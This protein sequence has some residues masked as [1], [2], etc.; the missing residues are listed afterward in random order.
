MHSK[1][2]PESATRKAIMEEVP[3]MERAEQT[4]DECKAEAEAPSVAPLAASLG[5]QTSRVALVAQ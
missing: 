4:V 2:N 3:A 1:L 5:A